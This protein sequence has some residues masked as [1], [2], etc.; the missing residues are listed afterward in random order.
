MALARVKKHTMDHFLDED[1][2]S[3]LNWLK[4]ETLPGIWSKGVQSSRNSKSIEK[5]FSSPDQKEFRFKILTTERTLAFEITLWI[6]ERDAHCNCGS[7]VEPCHHIV[8]ASL[9]LANRTVTETS[10]N[11]TQE[12]SDQ[13]DPTPRMLYR[14][15]YLPPEN[16][17]LGKMRFQRILLEKGQERAPPSSLASWI[18]GVRSGRLPG[19]LPSLSSVDLMLDEIYA[20]THPE[21]S[22]ILKVLSGLPPLPVEGHPTW[23]ALQARSQPERTVLTL[24]DS[25]P[26]G[27]K[28]ESA[29]DLELEPLQGG[30]W[31]RNG[32]IGFGFADP[33]FISKK[34]EKTQLENFLLREL[35][36]LQDQY[37]V[38]IETSQLP[39]LIHREPKLHLNV[40]ALSGGRF[41]VT[42]TADYGP[43][44]SGILVRDRSAE[45]RIARQARERLNLILNEPKIVPASILFEIRLA[46]NSV[47][48]KASDHF[49]GLE[50]LNLALQDDLPADCNLDPGIIL[51]LLRM[52]E[53]NP[54]Q[55]RRITSMIRSLSNPSPAVRIS[56][57]EESSD[58]RIPVALESRLRDY[59]KRGCSWLQNAKKNL[60]GAIL[61]DD[62][63][64]GK[65][66]QTLAILE[67]PSLVVMPASLVRNWRDEATKFRPDLRVSVYHGPERCWV[68]PNPTADLIL[69][70]YSILR[71]ESERFS[72]IHWKTV[73]LDEAHIIRNPETQSA[74]ASTLLSADFRLALTGTPIQNRIRDLFSLFQFVAPGLFTR[75]SDF[76]PKLTAPFFLRRT[77]AEVLPE[78]P[79][80]TYIEH[81]VELS[82]EERV[83]YESVLRAARADLIAR[84]SEEPR[85]L[86]PLTLLESLLRARQACSHEGLLDH[87]RTGLSS[88]KLSAIVELASELMD[89]GHTILIYSQWTR[90]L[91]LLESRLEGNHPLFR[92][93]GST[94][95]RGGLLEQFESSDRPS[96]FLLSLHAGGVGLNL[97]K[98][99]HVI[100]CE[101]W[102]NP[103]VELQ[104]EDRAY[105]MGQEKPVTIHRFIASDTLEEGLRALQARKLALGDA[106]L[107]TRDLEQLLQ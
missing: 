15:I 39:G 44:D 41:S 91:D 17:N 21:W 9:A 102:W 31:L 3:Y 45:A 105:R 13:S 80:K 87:S 106:A 89:G 94:R 5:T 25:P 34:L 63:G 67:G 107:D 71:M 11:P 33:G 38:R 66:I 85:S 58:L 92:L 104:A 56:E 97:V 2:K 43:I 76:E 46:A 84:L 86:N 36:A 1:L 57:A 40:V 47:S 49:S 19:P 90:F 29:R 77:K 48:P 70:T 16:Q 54:G 32:A 82:H 99:S 65:T 42:A 95:D 26:G 55:N 8:A 37:E 28:L 14:W 10:G 93:D 75:E 51:R 72:S 69:T 81:G 98:A 7:K 50:S 6:H 12:L 24:S 88:S 101:P 4:E 64:L 73:V 61:A 20:S 79:P 103:Y 18:A 53:E 35:P 23:K 100:F 59:Q 74:I 30:L 78:L 96:I 52:K 68:D 83:V 62:M 60:G 22:Q 27:F